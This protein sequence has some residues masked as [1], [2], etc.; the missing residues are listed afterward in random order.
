[1]GSID[2]FARKI[3]SLVNKPNRLLKQTM[4]T[5]RDGTLLSVKMAKIFQL[6]EALEH[7]YLVWPMLHENIFGVG[8]L[9]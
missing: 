7:Q 8:H 6:R 1:M 3:Q 2:D 9:E 5:N 4:M